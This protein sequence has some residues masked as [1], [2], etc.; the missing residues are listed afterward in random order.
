MLYH[1]HLHISL[2]DLTITEILSIFVE[3]NTDK[4]GLNT[5]IVTFYQCARINIY[6][7]IYIKMRGQHDKKECFIT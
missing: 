4:I 3:C 7:Y 1:F 5:K 2:F 6:I